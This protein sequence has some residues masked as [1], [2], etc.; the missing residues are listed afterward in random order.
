MEQS[1][2]KLRTVIL[3]LVSLVEMTLFSAPLLGWPSLIIILKEEQIASHLCPRLSIQNGSQSINYQ[4]FSLCA[5]QEKSLNLSHNIAV[6]VMAV[7]VFLAGWAIDRYGAKPVKIFSSAMFSLSAALFMFT[8][9]KTPETLTPALVA[10]VIAN[11]GLM[12]SIVKSAVLY[13][14]WKSTANSIFLCALTSSAVTFLIF[15]VTYVL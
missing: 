1:L 2:S 5:E 7:Y 3:F 4:H 13:G 10:T 6:M 9:S 11:V 8:T 15:K 14:K 12:L